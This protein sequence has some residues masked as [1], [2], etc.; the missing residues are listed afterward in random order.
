LR[1]ETAGLLDRTHLRW[2]TR[3]TI[4]EMFETSGFRVVEGGGRV[5][6]EPEREKFLPA[7]AALARVGDRDAELAIKDAIPWQ[8]LVR[9]EP[10]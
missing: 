4:G 6:D 3:I 9:A 5:M 1:Y 10:I 7:I 8:W 2:F